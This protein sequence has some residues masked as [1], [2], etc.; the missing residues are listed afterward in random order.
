MVLGASHV[1]AVASYC[2]GVCL[3]GNAVAFV[4]LP[5]NQVY[6]NKLGT[7]EFVKFSFETYKYGKSG[8]QEMLYCGFFF[9]IKINYF[10]AYAYFCSFN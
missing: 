7:Y 4:K 10:I 1:L 9:G 3:S 5:R 6:S 8:N 2:S